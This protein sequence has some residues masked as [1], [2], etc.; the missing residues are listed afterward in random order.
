MGGDEVCLWGAPFAAL[1]EPL[2]RLPTAAP[3]DETQERGPRV[4]GVRLPRRADLFK[5]F[6]WGQKVS[7][8]RLWP[9]GRME[10]PLAAEV[11]RSR[12]AGWPHQ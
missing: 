9:V 6:I 7:P 12:V 8:A 11:T 5:D 2:R 3:A 4:L 10:P 1:D